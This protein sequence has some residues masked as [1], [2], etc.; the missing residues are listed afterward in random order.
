METTTTIRVKKSTRE[1]L[2]KLAA[3][4]RVSITKLLEELVA[5]HEKSFWDGF[6]D[7]ALH[8]LNK[9]EKKTRKMFEKVLKDGL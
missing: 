6:N 7:E 2:K 8:A 9:S 5:R 3:A 1:R 4:G